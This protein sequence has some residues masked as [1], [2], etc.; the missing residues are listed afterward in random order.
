M[1]LLLRALGDEDEECEHLLEVDALPP[2]PT[3]DAA[4]VHHG[5]HAAAAVSGAH[6]AEYALCWEKVDVTSRLKMINVCQCM[7][8]QSGQMVAR[9]SRHRPIINFC[10]KLTHWTS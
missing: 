5:A 3:A 2:A 1:L 4:A 10:I 7:R 9:F 8:A 6:Q